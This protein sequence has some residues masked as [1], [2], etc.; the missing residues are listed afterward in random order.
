MNAKQHCKIETP[1]VILHCKPVGCRRLLCSL[2]ALGLLSACGTANWYQAGKSRG[3]IECRD[4]P[5]GQYEECMHSYDKTYL[6]YQKER[7]EAIKK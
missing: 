2:A 4:Q 6:Q 3:E 1:T 7:E 5:A